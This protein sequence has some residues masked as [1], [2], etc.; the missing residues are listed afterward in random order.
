VVDEPAERFG[1]AT[2]RIEMTEDAKADLSCYTA[3]ERKLILSE[4][5]GQLTHQPSVITRNRKALRENPIARWELR[6]DEFR[7]SYELDE[8]SETVVIVAIGHKEHESLLIRGKKV[9]L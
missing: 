6:V 7:V 2:Y 9:Q 5:R 8:E 4:I 1:M 3:F